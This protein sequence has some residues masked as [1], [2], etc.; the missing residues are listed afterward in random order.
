MVQPSAAGST[1]AVKR[2]ITPSWRS[3]STRR[4]VAAVD[5]PMRW[6]RAAKLSRPFSIR[7]RKNL[8]IDIVKTQ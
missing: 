1:S 2:R 7:R 6:P 4:L 8:V 5:S 3:R